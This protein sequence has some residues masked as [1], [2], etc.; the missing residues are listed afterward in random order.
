MAYQSEYKIYFA[1]K[2]KSLRSFV[3]WERNRC[4]VDFTHDCDIAVL[5]LYGMDS[6]LKPEEL[7]TIF[8]NTM[9]GMTEYLT[10]HPINTS[11]INRYI[12]YHYSIGVSPDKKYILTGAATGQVH[13][14]DILSGEEIPLFEENINIGPI[15]SIQFSPVNETAL[16]GGGGGT[17]LLDIPSKKVVK[18]FR[19]KLNWTSKSCFSNNGLYILSGSIPN[20]LHMYD[21]QRSKLFVFQKMIS[22]L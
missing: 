16:I 20:R 11:G 12:N 4:A 13:L 18:E 17:V 22:S 7:K 15:F 3:G 14:W 2:D 6:G 9:T 10:F 1:G 8:W 5:C 21:T 19:S